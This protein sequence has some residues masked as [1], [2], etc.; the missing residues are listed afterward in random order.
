MTLVLRGTI[1]G[2]QKLADGYSLR[3]S[4]GLIRDEKAIVDLL[5]IAV[6]LLR[7]GDSDV[8]GR[9]DSS[10]VA[11]ARYASAPDCCSAFALRWKNSGS[12]CVRM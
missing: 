3:I 9:S 1:A 10:H 12:V 5:Q 4:T 7:G 11:L 2:H 6:S 8:D